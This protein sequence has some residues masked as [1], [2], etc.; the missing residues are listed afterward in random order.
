ML[1]AA[2]RGE[3]QSLYIIGEDPLTTYP[4]REFVERALKGIN[5][6][7]VEDIVM[8]ETAKMADF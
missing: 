1:E 4:D 2:A 6:L 3:M 5:F 8:T 7:L